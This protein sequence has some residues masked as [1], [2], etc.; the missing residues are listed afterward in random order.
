MTYNEQQQQLLSQYIDGKI[1]LS[2]LLLK[3]YNPTFQDSRGDSILHIAV[4][5]FKIDDVNSILEN[6]LISINKT[7]YAGETALHSSCYR[8]RKD[9]INLLLKHNANP[10]LQNNKGDTPFMHLTYDCDFITAEYILKHG[11]D[12]NLPNFNG[13]TT[14]NHF[15]KQSHLTIIKS[16]FN[17]KELCH[18]IDWNITDKNGNN[19]FEAITFNFNY[20][21]TPTPTE[22]FVIPYLLKYGVSFNNINHDGEKPLLRALQSNKL[23]LVKSFI[24]NKAD[25]NSVNS[26]NHSLG[27]CL[28][29]LIVSAEKESIRHFPNNNHDLGQIA[30]LNSISKYIAS[31]NLYQPT[32][33]DIIKKIEHAIESKD[34]GKSKDVY[35]QYI[36]N[37]TD[38]QNLLDYALTKCLNPWSPK[39]QL[40]NFF[41]RMGADINSDILNNNKDYHHEANGFLQALTSTSKESAKLIKYMIENKY[42]FSN[43]INGKNE[44]VL[45][46]LIKSNNSRHGIITNQQI[47]INQQDSNNNTPL[48]IFF[49]QNNNFGTTGTALYIINN[50]PDVNIKNNDGKTIYDAFVEWRD[51]Q[52]SNL[53]S[54]NNVVAEIT[55][56][57]EL[58]YLDK[59]LLPS[60]SLRKTNNK[61]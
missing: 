24:N 21:T 45:H 51:K 20:D 26:E 16:I 27:T 52:N 43:T 14:L 18:K 33:D 44:N 50:N 60:N 28:D 41:I 22:E 11:I 61:I 36:S 6:K 37:S 1:S 54:H 10:N 46:Y 5:N 32:T 40:S 31:N 2:Q 30:K 42:D 13:T 55:S 35:Q 57:M 38:K 39:I 34:L 29:Q 25:L 48:H 15:I 12:L 23:H 7:N 56:K 19:L 49:E 58:L 47:N 8:G 3:K 17:N 59:T 9:M 53:S 4:N